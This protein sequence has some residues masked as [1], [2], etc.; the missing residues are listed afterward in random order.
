[1]DFLSYNVGLIT[2]S[3]LLS[4]WEGAGGR[5]HGDRL[6]TW[7]TKQPQGNNSSYYLVLY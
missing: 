4:G 1:M 5:V 2:L 6:N 7:V 3:Q